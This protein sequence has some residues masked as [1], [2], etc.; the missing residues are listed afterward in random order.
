MTRVQESTRE[1]D[2]MWV[3]T[4][5][6]CIIDVEMETQTLDIFIISWKCNKI[7]IYSILYTLFLYVII[8]VILDTLLYV[9]FTVHSIRYL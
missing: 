2:S 7:G 1:T 9:I 6:N 3:R 4:L 5:I 8:Y